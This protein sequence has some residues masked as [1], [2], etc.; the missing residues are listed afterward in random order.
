MDSTENQTILAY[1][2]TFFSQSG[3]HGLD[4]ILRV[5][6]LSQEIGVAEGAD[7]RVL[8]PAALFH[9]I[10]RPI[11]D[12]TGIPHQEE[13]GAR[14]AEEYLRKAGYDAARIAAIVHAIRSHRFS[15]GPEPE[16]LEAQVLSDADN[17][18][19]MG[20]VGIARTFMRAGER[21]G[22]GIGGGAVGHIHEKLLKLQGG[23]MYT[24]TAQ[25]IA[26]QRH[27]LLQRFVESLE[28]ETATGRS[29]AGVFLR[30]SVK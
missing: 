14:I 16:T 18:D 22:D 24:D 1:V 28:D 11:E 26:E 10:A 3:T 15:T 7:M 27:A 6:R 13:G 23:L 25:E 29:V 9:D 12:E 8:I 2:E 5:T 20:A 21:G 4:H 17:L 30:G 19:A